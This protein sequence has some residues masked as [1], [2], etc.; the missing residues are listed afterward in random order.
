M[1]MHFI[2]NIP[3]FEEMIIKKTETIGDSFH[4]HVE[5]ERKAQR[6][7]DC[8]KR[9]K[10]VH[11]YRTQKVQHLKMFE[12]NTYVF[13]RKRRYACSC[14]KRF[15]EST[16]FVQ[17]YQRHSVEWNQA[18]GLRIIQG[19]NFKDTAQQFRTSASTAMRRFDAISSPMFREV[20]ELP[21]VIA[22]D[23]YKGDTDQGKFQ[24]I[25]A[26]GKTGEP[27]DIL[28]DRKVETVKQYLRR[29]GNKVEM[30]VMD[31]SYPF[32]SAVQKA[33]GNPVI[34]A[35]RFHFC[36]Y[37]FWALDRVRRRVQKDFHEY[38]RKKCKRMK[39]VFNK[40]YEALSEKQHWYLERYLG[41]SEELR[42]AYRLK[43]MFRG[44]FDQAKAV[45]SSN[46]RIIKE[47]LYAFYRE[48]KASG[49]KEF[50]KVVQ[51][52][53]NWQTEILNS[54]TFGYTN[55]PIEGLNNQ[56]KVIKRNAFG[57]KRYDR[58]RMRVLLHH[59]VKGKTIQVG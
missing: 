58:L 54:F 29:K 39:H 27:L 26:N 56:T 48:V 59:Q 10:R 19:K 42:S 32:K 47:G 55:G 41:L 23:E 40:R 7:P 11:D 33:L 8:G 57:F 35:D 21:G 14:G 51:T 50:I 52:L 49:M 30:V 25:I 13:Y 44:W 2:M 53:Q 34:I 12:R 45:G 4:L 15:A 24:V 17:R 37:V 6:C 22:I 5:M 1:Y 36:R 20:T 9:T 46:G 38:D 3:G 43:E 28:P 16:R 31:M 18:F